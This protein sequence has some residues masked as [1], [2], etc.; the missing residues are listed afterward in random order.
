MRP[1]LL[2]L[3]LLFF[4]ITTSCQ[5]K[6]TTDLDPSAKITLDD[7]ELVESRTA[8]TDE[9]EA[10]SFTV[11]YDSQKWKK[12]PIEFLTILKAYKLT[13]ASSFEIDAEMSGINLEL[14]EDLA[15][16]IDVG[17]EIS[18]VDHVLMVE[19]NNVLGQTDSTS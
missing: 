18:L 12:Q 15:T 8:A 2:P 16:P 19:V 3:L 6:S 5:E 11:I 9:T 17:K 7:T 4:L 10:V 13:K 1:H 14:K